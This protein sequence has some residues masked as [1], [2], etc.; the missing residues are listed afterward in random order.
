MSKLKIGIVMPLAEQ[1]GGAELMLMHLLRGVRSI[2]L[3]A[4]YE[5]A[6]LEDGPMQKEV[7]ALGIPTRVFKAGHLRQPVRYIRTVAALARWMRTERFDAV[8]SWMAKAHL[9]AG[10]AVLLTKI[11]ACWFQHGLPE[12]HWMDR[13]VSRI[14]AKGIFACSQAGGPRSFGSPAGIPFVSYIRPS[15]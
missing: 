8:L 1:R 4:T 3:P 11:P 9:Y 13:L 12:R 6:F 2:P 10:P 14:P 15:I 7:S 5:V